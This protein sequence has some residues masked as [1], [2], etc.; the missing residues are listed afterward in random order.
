MQG[1]SKKTFQCYS[2]SSAW[3][4]KLPDGYL[5][6]DLP[7]IFNNFFVNKISDI[8]QKLD[9]TVNPNKKYDEVESATTNLK[10]LIPAT[11]SEIHK[12]IMSSKNCS[13]SSDPIPT[14]VLKKCVYPG[15]VLLA[16]VTKIVNLSI[17]LGQFPSFHKHALVKPL[18]KKTNL[19]HNVL[20]NFTPVSNLPF[21]SKIIE[22]TVCNR[23]I[24]HLNRNNLY[25]PLQSAYRK[26]HSTETGLVKLHNDILINLD[27]NRGVVLIL[28]DLSAAF[29]TIDH[30]LMIKR[31]ENR[32]GI[33]A[34]AL[35]WFTSYLQGCSQTVYI[36][37]YTSESITSFW[38]ASRF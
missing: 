26:G 32:I 18:L 29:D 37:G 13:T 28:L 35:E 9:S 15:S 11:E 38:R 24:E 19:D 1:R 10:E 12:I 5:G 36:D 21:L 23:L 6:S 3:Q 2:V 34:T 25:E 27:S 17:E 8:R 30:S 22:K 4:T 7:Q 14:S 20:K 33:K 16:F 31:L